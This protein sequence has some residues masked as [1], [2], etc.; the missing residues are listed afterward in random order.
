MHEILLGLALCG[1]CDNCGGHIVR[2]IGNTISS[3]ITTDLTYQGMLSH[4]KI[5]KIFEIQHFHFTSFCLLTRRASWRL[6]SHWLHTIHGSSLAEKLTLQW[7]LQRKFHWIHLYYENGCVHSL[8]V[9]YVSNEGKGEG[10]LSGQMYACSCAWR[11][12]LT[13]TKI[14][15]S[16]LQKSIIMSWHEL[17]PFTFVITL[18]LMDY[19]CQD[20]DSI[21]FR[22]SLPKTPMIYA[23]HYPSIVTV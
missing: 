17:A 16:L 8:A 1:S 10:S 15:K 19:V 9:H 20:L 4:F 11:G 18:M 12:H 13:S 22:L 3:L 23:R 6:K 2:L 21:A 14:S 7:I 5:L